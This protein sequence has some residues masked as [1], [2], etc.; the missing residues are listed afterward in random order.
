VC[1]CVWV[2]VCVCV[3]VCVWV[4]LLTSLS[5]LSLPIPHFLSIPLHILPSFSFPPSPSLSPLLSLS[6]TVPQV[7][8]LPSSP[9]SPHLPPLLPL[10][11]CSLQS[12]TSSPTLYSSSLPH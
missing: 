3:C 4:S 5:F 10:C 11:V 9:P 8:A 7:S 2:F 12:V 1:V 6:L